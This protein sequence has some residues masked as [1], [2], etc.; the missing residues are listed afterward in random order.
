MGTFTFI[1]HSLKKTKETL[2]R[3]GRCSGRYSNRASLNKIGIISSY[4]HG[5]I[6]VSS[7][8]ASDIRPRAFHTMNFGNCILLEV[9]MSKTDELY[10]SKCMIVT[11]VIYTV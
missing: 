3:D 2:R 7:M 1:L 4:G 5:G 9:T 11:F 6:S 10:T 8:N